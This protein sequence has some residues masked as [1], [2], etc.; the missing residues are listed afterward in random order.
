MLFLTCSW[1]DALAHLHNWIYLSHMLFWIQYALYKS[2]G[3]EKNKYI[4]LFENQKN[5]IIL[6]LVLYYSNL[7]IH[8]CD[9]RKN[10]VNELKHAFFILTLIIFLKIP[11]KHY[12]REYVYFSPFCIRKTLDC[13][14]FIFQNVGTNA[15]WNITW[16]RSSFYQNV[17]FEQ[18]QMY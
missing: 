8:I 12:P 14:L 10:K 5:Q 6:K 9:Q 18:N 11:R 2:G 15:S 3:C 17:A 1:T 4:Y 7:R 13:E 16:K